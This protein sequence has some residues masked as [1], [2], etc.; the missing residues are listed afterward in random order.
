MVN[1]LPKSNSIV[2]MSKTTMAK[3]LSLSL[4]SDATKAD[5]ATVLDSSCGNWKGQ[6]YVNHD[7]N[8]NILKET[9]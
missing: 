2:S 9:H 8:E 4:S 6:I 7:L 5:Q 1:K 3:Q